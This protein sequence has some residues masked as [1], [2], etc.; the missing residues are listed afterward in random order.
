[1][2]E[3]ACPILP[4]RDF[5][6]TQ[7]FYADLGFDTWYKDEGYLLM[8][9]EKVELRFFAKPENRPETCDHGVYIRPTNV[10]EFSDRV[11]QLGL[12]QTGAFPKFIPA[13]DKTWG[14]REA[15]LWDPDGN[16]LRIGEVIADG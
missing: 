2:W 1:M 15:A 5:D 14:M 12:P 3:Q 6:A 10:D 8:N 16:L 9:N 11:A 13:E 7:N 4:S